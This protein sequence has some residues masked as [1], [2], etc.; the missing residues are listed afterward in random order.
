MFGRPGEFPPKEPTQFD[1][2]VFFQIY[3]PEESAKEDPQDWE[4]K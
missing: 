1:E 3:E 4:W 2:P